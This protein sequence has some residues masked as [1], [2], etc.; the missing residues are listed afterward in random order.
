M[1]G[2]YLGHVHDDVT[3]R[4]VFRADVFVS[5][6]RKFPTRDVA[7]ACGTPSAAFEI[8]GLPDLVKRAELVT[9]HNL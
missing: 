8:G 9:W 7:A 6:S 2:H 5:P 3:L 4:T 1:Q